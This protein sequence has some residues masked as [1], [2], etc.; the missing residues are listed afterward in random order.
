MTRTHRRRSSFLPTAVVGALA[1]VPL[2][3]APAQADDEI[4]LTV[5]ATTD[6]HGH[7]YNWDYFADAPYTGN[8][9][10]GMSRAASIVEQVRGERAP[11]SVLLLDNGD[12]IQG[13]P[14]TYLAQRDEGDPG[15][16]TNPMAEAFNA[17]DYDALNLGNHEF[18]YGLDLL[19]DVEDS[20]DA[21]L[22]GANVVD[23]TTGDPAFQP[24]EIIERVID[25]HTVKV[26][27]LGLVTPGVRVW[28]K[29]IVDGVLEFRDLVA[30]ARE[31]VPEMKA[32]GAEIV[33][34]LVH[35]GLDADGYEW[36]EADLEENVAASV[37]SLVNDIDLVIGGHSHVDVPARVFAA[38]D[39]DPVLFT[40]P[41]F[42]ARSVSD[43]QLPL[44]RTAGG[45]Y[46]VDWP[47]SDEA[48]AAL[49]TPRYARDYAD[50]ALLTENPVLAEQH[51]RTVDYVNTTVAT[52][53]EEMT[54]ATSRYED[55]PI[56]DLIGQVMVDAVTLG[57]SET[58]YAGLPVVAQTSPF[59]R[60][61]V[62][63]AGDLT[64]KDI[65]G[66]YIYD[67]TLQA[68][69]MTGAQ[70]KAYL[71]YSAR[72]FKQATPEDP[73]DPET[74]TGALYPG[75]TRGIPDY[76]YDA[77]T[78]VSYRIDVTRP[79]GERIVDLAWDGAPVADDDR[80]VLAVNNY[81]ANGGGGFPVGDMVPIW[82]EQLEIR[83]LII[84][85]A[86]QAG[87]LDQAAFHEANWSL[88]TQA[89]E[90]TP[91]DTTSP[92]VSPSPDPSD[93]TGPTGT[94]TPSEPG[95]SAPASASPSSTRGG[96]LGSTGASVGGI[97]AVA[98]GLAV[99]GGL[100]LVWRRR[101]MRTR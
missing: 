50:S 72:Y 25:G 41:Y 3:A 11:D 18:N 5:L 80:L 21:P 14:L 67:N 39:G 90:P 59:S 9:Q 75:E 97:V 53:L 6:V 76:N 92:S 12:A 31:V 63:P 58:E 33:V 79:V 65:A 51:T 32:D 17:L 54:T 8:N 43:V 46:R 70:L 20:Y 42:W 68:S 23:A 30:T 45:A 55:T 95:S 78:G 73:W 56:L 10:L 82:D 61:S 22:L 91:T 96:E 27:V 48:V 81:R 37:A 86:T 47:A 83:Q 62:F 2:L 64:I 87:E 93:P 94:T 89:E 74:H 38:P 66:L 1:L 100:A 26:G 15:W 28:D 77:L 13:T 34:A 4:T 57:L 60:T 88:I 98:L 71:E 29:A 40:Q 36:R 49:V 101:S 16:E 19:G 7:V 99:V 24:Y 85:Y 44:T 69:L 52:N 35:S 84:E